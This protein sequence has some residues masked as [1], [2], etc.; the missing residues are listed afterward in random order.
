M[1]NVVSKINEMKDNKRCKEQAAS[2]D[3][4]VI[5][6]VKSA[7]V[8]DDMC[9]LSKSNDRITPSKRLRKVL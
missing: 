3:K 9:D 7:I 1:E 6:V 2:V 8:R 4:V 5:R